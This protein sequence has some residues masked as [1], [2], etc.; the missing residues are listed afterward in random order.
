VAFQAELFVA[1]LGASRYLYAK[2]I[3]SQDLQSFVTAHVHALAFFGAAPKVLV[4]DSAAN[5]KHAAPP[6]AERQ[7]S[8]G[9]IGQPS[10]FNLQVVQLTVTCGPEDLVDTMGYSTDTT[11]P[12]EET[13]IHHGSADRRQPV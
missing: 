9:A 7:M 8:P 1:V 5:Q 2:A 10:W 3:R 6:P 4:P 12:A 13:R 11:S